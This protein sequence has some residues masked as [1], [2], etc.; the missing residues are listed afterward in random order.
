MYI[1]IGTVRRPCV[2]AEI[3]HFAA[4][5]CGLFRGPP[6]DLGAYIDRERDIDIDMCIYMYCV[7][8]CVDPAWRPKFGILQPRSAVCFVDHLT[9]SV[10]IYSYIYI[11][12]YIYIDMYVYIYI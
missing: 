2:E 7:V 6:H 3:W 8:Q 9:T 12:R 5:Q 10:R 11:E 1:Y 4:A